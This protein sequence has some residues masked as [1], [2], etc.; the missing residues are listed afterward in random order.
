MAKELKETGDET[1]DILIQRARDKGYK[2]LFMTNSLEEL[3][4]QT[5]MDLN[6]LQ[7]TIDEYNKFCEDGSDPIFNKKPENLRPVKQPPFYAAR[8]YPS[9]Y[10]TL[11]GI[12]INHKTEA[13]T[14]NF[15][16]IP[17]LYAAGSDANS[18]Y[19][20][21]YI[22]ILPGNTLGFALNSGRIAGENAT[23]YVKSIS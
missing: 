17:G 20:D 12:K 22:I 19:G 16:V 8:L 10:G 5:G 9:A 7:A 18:L 1:L 2:H 15:D 11:G 3:C 21:T 23:K 4:A 13:I 14:K 6:G